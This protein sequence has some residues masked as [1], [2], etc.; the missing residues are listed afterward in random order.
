MSDLKDLTDEQLFYKARS[1][2]KDAL[3][4]IAGIEWDDSLHL[5][6]VINES[7]A[8][9]AEFH[10]RLGRQTEAAS[11]LKHHLTHGQ[12]FRHYEVGMQKALHALGEEIT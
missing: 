12:H 7:N 8:L 10:R 1:N 11:I 6:G 4:V 9:L 3:A 2:G 5:L